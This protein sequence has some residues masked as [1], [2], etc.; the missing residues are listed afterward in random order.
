[1]NR[2]IAAKKT[3]VMISVIVSVSSMVFQLDASGV[4]HHGLNRWNSTEPTTMM[5]RTMAMTMGGVSSR[6]CTRSVRGASAKRVD[7]WRFALEEGLRV[8]RAQKRLDLPGARGRRV[9]H[10][11]DPPLRH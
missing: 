5:R 7:L 9:D 11:Q 2:L 1:M 6:H 10:Q 3:P 4:V 8:R